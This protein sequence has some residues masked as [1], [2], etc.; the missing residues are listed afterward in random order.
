MFYIKLF[1]V[2]I[3]ISDTW[4]SGVN[5]LQ[6]RFSEEIHNLRPHNVEQY[7]L[8]IILSTRWSKL[9]D[10]CLKY[11]QKSNTKSYINIIFTSYKIWM[12][13]RTFCVYSYGRP[14]LCNLALQFRTLVYWLYHLQMSKFALFFTSKVKNNTQ[15]DR[16]CIAG[17]ARTLRSVLFS[18]WSVKSVRNYV[19]LR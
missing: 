9:V 15:M 3:I 17:G 7:I 4:N 10:F 11:G 18:L 12:Q 2:Q 13:E 5:P 6:P 19:G 8:E 16:N 14:K 1:T